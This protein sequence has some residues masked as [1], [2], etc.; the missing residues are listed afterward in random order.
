MISREFNA[1]SEKRNDPLT[2]RLGMWIFLCSELLLF[3][4]L[5]ILY[6]VALRR[7]PR[8]FH[9]AAM[10]MNIFF[11]GANTGILITSSLCVALSVAALKRRAKVRSLAFLAGAILM[12]IA[13]LGVKAVEWSEKINHGIYPNAPELL[14]RPG[15]EVFYFNL[16]YLMTGLHGV[17]VAVGVVA[18]G[19]VWI[20]IHNDRIHG[21]EPVILENCGLYWHL[22]DIIWIY[23][24][25]L[26]YLI[27]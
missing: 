23:L 4:A 11:G 3:G 24:F 19:I 9:L 26:F 5:F 27:T 7:Y 14:A 15:G 17:H 10:E 8:E 20:L 21:G 18:L 2:A 1:V 12:A 22:V 6:G 13:F 16:Y 25:P